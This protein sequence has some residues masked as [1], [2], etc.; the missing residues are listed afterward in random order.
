MSELAARRYVKALYEL[1]VEAGNQDSILA[2]LKQLNDTFSN[3]EDLQ[4]I[5]H[6]PSYSRHNKLAVVDEIISELKVSAQVAGIVKLLIRKSRVALLPYVVEEYAAQERERKGIVRMEISTAHPLDEK[7]RKELIETFTKSTGKQVEIEATVD[8]TLI[9]GM[10]ARIGG[11]IY[12]GSIDHQLN[13]IKQRL[14]E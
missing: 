6:N 11:T 12:D 3:S 10:V 7:A 8:E 9:G 1:A 13:L 2:E 4:Q 14:G 5:L